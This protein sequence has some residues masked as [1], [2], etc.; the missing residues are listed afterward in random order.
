MHA[1]P[2]NATQTFV[3]RIRGTLGIQL[4]K[5][6]FFMIM[7]KM[8][9]AGSGFLFWYLAAHFYSV[10]DVGIATALISSTSLILQF[11]YF[12]FDYSIIRFYSK[13]DRSKMFSTCLILVLSVALVLSGIYIV[14]VRWFSPELA[15]I[16]TPVYAAIFLTF[17]AVSVVG[18]ICAITFIA[19]R[20]TELNFVQNLLM[21]SR[22]PLLIPLAFLGAFG[23][24]TSMGIAYVIVCIIVLYLISRFISMRIQVDQAFVRQ[25]LKFSSGNYLAQILLNITY[26]L[27]PIIILNM[28]GSDAA[29]KYYIAYTIGNFL[30]QV[31]DAVGTSLFVEGSHGES[32]RKNVIRAA[33]AIYAILIPGVIF[34]YIFGGQILGVFGKDYTE[35]IEL[36]RIFAFTSLFF[37][38]YCLMVPVLNVRMNVKRV[39]QLNAIIFVLFMGMSCLFL[40]WL[41]ITGAGLALMCTYIIMDVIILAL[42]RKEGMI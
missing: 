41:G 30:L 38:I 37:A 28:L 4:F 1:T 39:I 40:T 21:I 9:M 19:A 24:L 11:S 6:S 36:L 10:G 2:A 8:L 35:S 34:F 29:A 13:Y 12:G 14:F 31:P 27:L 18:Q 17:I 5:N 7:N 23:I 25:S 22:I 15:F 26:L 33:A 20:K 3:S 42:A 32:M 16:Q